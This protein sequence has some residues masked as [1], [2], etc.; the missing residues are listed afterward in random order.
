[1]QKALQDEAEA[2]A[3]L[4][5]LQATLKLKFVS[6]EISWTSMDVRLVSFPCVPSKQQHQ[7]VSGVASRMADTVHS[8]TP[9]HQR[10]VAIGRPRN[11]RTAQVA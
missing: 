10:V 9:P 8:P 1:M 4:K 3:V 11:Q 5:E 7:S 2:Q 6:S